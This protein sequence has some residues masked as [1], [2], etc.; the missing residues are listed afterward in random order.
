MNEKVI[1]QLKKRIK[2]WIVLFIVGLVV[3]GI[4]AFP[5]EAQ[6]S[7]LVKHLSYFPEFLHDWINE[8]YIGIVSTNESFPFISYGT[9]WLGFAHIVI[10]V[11][12][13]G[14]Y[15]NPVKNIWVIQF[16]MIAC[17]MVIPFAFIAGYLRDIPFYWRL[18]DISFGI[19]GFIP[20]YF[21][22]RNI[23]KLEQ[24]S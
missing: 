24:L 5:V 19:F 22:Y 16:G 4:T 6:L 13:I 9:D 15:I 21:T 2:V 17:L 18:I 7:F 1:N 14:P 20:L 23:K 3:S 8:V 11:A 10:A 12:F